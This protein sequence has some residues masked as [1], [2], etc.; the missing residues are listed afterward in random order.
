M[1]N[2]R[3]PLDFVAL[4]K[5]GR[6]YGVKEDDVVMNVRNFICGVLVDEFGCYAQVM[7]LQG[8][9]WVRWSAQIYLEESDFEWA[10]DVVKG[11][12]ERAMKGEWVTGRKGLSR[13]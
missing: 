5:Y 4:K 11:V 3:L 9:L 13:L 12:C 1:S 2:V 7:P 6:E 10:G 8:N